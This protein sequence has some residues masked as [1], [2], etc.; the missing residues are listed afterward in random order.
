VLQQRFDLRR[1]GDRGWNKEEG[2]IRAHRVEQHHVSNEIFDAYSGL[3]RGGMLPV[4]HEV[5]SQVRNSVEAPV[6]LPPPVSTAILERTLCCDPV[7]Q[8][9]EHEDQVDHWPHTQST[10]GEADGVGVA[11][12][13]VVMN[14]ARV[15]A[16][17]AA[18]VGVVTRVVVDK[19]E[20]T[21]VGVGVTDEEVL[22]AVEVA[23]EV[24]EGS[25]AEEEVVDEDSV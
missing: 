17:V 20:V 5:E 24:I 25:V 1:K 14:R 13:V 9:I 15:A 12:A 4:G 6:Q 3:A 21:E 22:V 18:D 23:V 2:R 16:V 11:E 7:P 8:V 10:G 19:V